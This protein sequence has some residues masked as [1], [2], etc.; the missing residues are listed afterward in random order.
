MYISEFEVRNFMSHNRS[1]IK[2]TP[3]TV[4]VGPN[5]GGKS[6]FFDSLLNFSMLSRGSVRQAFGPYPYSY[7]ATLNK[8]AIA[9]RSRVGFS[10]CIANTKDE[11]PKMKYEID[12]AQLTTS[13]ESQ[14]SF[15]IFNEKLTCLNTNT[16][17]FDRAYPENYSD[18]STLAITSDRTLFAA[19]RL[20][21]NNP[22]YKEFDPLIEDCVNQIAKFSKFRL[23]PLVLSHIS[24]MPDMLTDGTE[25]VA[26]RI[27]YHGEDLATSLY[28]LS[29]N[30]NEILESIINK[31]KNVDKSFSGFEFNIMGPDRV[32]FSLVFSD[33]RG[34]IPSVRVSSGLLTFIGL[35][36]LLLTPNRPTVLMIEEPENGLTPK[37]LKVFYET[38]K[39]LA[40]HE[41]STEA[42]QIII[43]S[44]SPFVICESWNGEDREFIHQVSIENGNSKITPFSAIVEKTG[45][46]LSK[47]AGKRE[48]L[49][50]KHAD[51]IMS[52]YFY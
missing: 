12:Y 19:I 34:S 30:S 38:L 46:P 15:Q 11:E 26:P 10:V 1:Q 23:D 39:E 17:L 16:V 37:A 6:A 50:L 5:S 31:V 41:N 25:M 35:I 13:D 51:Q 36:T 44:H 20:N 29:E 47:K 9:G 24:R 2:L 43:S 18:F 52:G 14:P 45:L 48:T 21:R 42:S 7:N 4:L 3:I 22:E 8:S 32:A 49:S 33:S 27:G 40:F 28:Y